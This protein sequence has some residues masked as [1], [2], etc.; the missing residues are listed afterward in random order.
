MISKAMLSFAAGVIFAPVTATTAFAQLSPTADWA[1]HAQNQYAVAANVTY[2]TATGYEAKL[3]VYRRRD[4]TDAAADAGL[5]PRRRLDRRH[6]GSVLHVDHAVARDGLERRERRV[7]H[8]ARRA[9]AGG[10]GRRAVRAALRRRTMP[11]T[12]TSTP[13]RSSSAANRRADIWRWPSGMIPATSGF[14]QHLRGRRIHRQRS[15]R[16]RRSRRSS[17]GTASPTSTTCSPGRT[18]APTRCSGSAAAGTA[19]RREERLAA[20]LRACRSAADP[21]HPGRCRS[22]RALFAERAAARRARQGRHA[23]TNCSRL[24]AAATAISSPSERT[25]GLRQDSPVPGEE[26][27][28][29][30][31]ARA[32][33]HHIRLRRKE[34]P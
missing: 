7:P 3:D 1:T 9:G 8:G 21:Q 25:Q 4:V 24:P 23:R 31:V 30:R 28:G 2:L 5:L 32:R 29:V 6:Q 15:R 27:L 26:R 22:D 14:T 10:G 11:R 12:T 18:R 34:Q 16:C 19:T 20:D 13:P 33:P 17:T